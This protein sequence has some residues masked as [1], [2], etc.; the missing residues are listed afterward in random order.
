MK[1]FIGCPTRGAVSHL[2]TETLLKLCQKYS[3]YT[4]EFCFNSKQPTD[5]NRNQIVEKFLKTDADV[6]LFIDDDMLPSE[7]L[8]D[9]IS[10][11]KDVMAPLTVIHQE[12]LKTNLFTFDKRKL[13]LDDDIVKVDACGC[14]CV[15]IKREVFNKVEKPYFKFISDDNGK[16]ILS[17]TF[18][19]YKKL[20][21]KKI[22]VFVNQNISIGHL[23]K[24]DL[25]YI[26]NVFEKGKEFGSKENK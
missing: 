6:L 13:N 22:D 14:G 24:I 7:E 19:F 11:D 21:E 12:Q 17:E 3:Q 4:Y 23:K 20:Y 15:F 10:F 2:L 1:L 5:S 18:Y 26:N 9:L 8:F 25:R 16:L